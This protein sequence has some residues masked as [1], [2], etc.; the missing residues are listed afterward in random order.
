MV[1]L[2]KESHACPCNIARSRRGMIGKRSQWARIRGQDARAP[3]GET[4]LL[5]FRGSAFTSIS[6][7]FLLIGVGVGYRMRYDTAFGFN[8]LRGRSYRDPRITWITLIV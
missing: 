5:T 6:R 3:A 8:R 4:P 1:F 7:A 2:V